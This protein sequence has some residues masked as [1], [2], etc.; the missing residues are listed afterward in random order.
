MT[1]N[2]FIFYL[3]GLSY[4]LRS[5][6]SRKELP[7]IGGIAIND[8]CN[9][10]CRHCFVSNRNIPDLSYEEIREGLLQLYDKGMKYLYIEGGEPF[11]W[12]DNSRDLEDVVQLARDIGF[13]YIVIYTNGTFPV[14]TS[15][16]LVFVSIDGLKDTHDA[17]RGKCYERIISNI[18]RSSHKKIY[19]NFTITSQNMSEIEEFCEETDKIRNLKG[20]NFYLYTPY[21]GKDELFLSYEDKRK[22]IE[23][24]LSLKKKGYH[25]LNSKTT[26]KSAYNDSWKRPSGLSYLYA[27]KKLYMCCRAIGMDDICENCGYL[28]FTEIFHMSRLNPDALMTAFKYY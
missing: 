26:L 16:N 22:I 21:N 3:S 2:K 1:F 10:H 11:L 12:K 28:G 9:L 5:G 27:E 13:R 7:F 24:I 17:M 14:E 8:R 19:A 25:I 15:A 4:L 6:I 20:V 18:N 23:N